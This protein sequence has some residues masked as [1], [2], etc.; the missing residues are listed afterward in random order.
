MPDH[1]ELNSTMKIRWESDMLEVNQSNPVP[2]AA[3]GRLQSHLGCATGVGESLPTDEAFDPAK[4]IA[5]AVDAACQR[6]LL[7]R[8]PQRRES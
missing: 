2:V 1:V 4:L 6:N 3:L 5:L 8:V 7:G